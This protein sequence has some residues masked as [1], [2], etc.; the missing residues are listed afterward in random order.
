MQSG[1]FARLSAIAAITRAETLCARW[2]L[3]VLL[4]SLSVGSSRAVADL[5]TTVRCRADQKAWFPKL[6]RDPAAANVS[7]DELNG[8]NSEMVNCEKVDSDFRQAYVDT[9]HLVIL[10][11][12]R[13]LFDFVN[14]HHLM[15]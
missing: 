12:S 10:T 8:W 2:A 6:N 4:L 13:R 11:Q 1:F 3:V 15:R 9:E 7:Y 5:L 14:R